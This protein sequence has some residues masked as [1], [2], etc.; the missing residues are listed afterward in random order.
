M[1]RSCL[2][3][4]S[5]SWHSLTLVVPMGSIQGNAVFTMYARTH[6]FIQDTT[7]SRSNETTIMTFKLAAPRVSATKKK[8]G[9]LHDLQH[10]REY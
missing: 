1:F 10:Y 6:S 2:Q 7:T 8:G 5:V 3:I 9:F 4:V